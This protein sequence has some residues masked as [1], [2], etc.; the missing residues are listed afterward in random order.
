MRLSNLPAEMGDFRS[1][2]PQA[3]SPYVTNSF[4]SGESI[5]MVMN[6][7]LRNV[8]HHGSQWC[9]LGTSAVLLG[10]IGSR[11]INV[12]LAE[13]H[14]TRGKEARPDNGGVS[15]MSPCQNTATATATQTHYVHEQ[16]NSG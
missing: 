10:I 2:K 11:L 4:L 14:R 1:R 16:G 12:V 9:S 6:H 7:V 13:S 8:Y 15:I 5:G 3:C